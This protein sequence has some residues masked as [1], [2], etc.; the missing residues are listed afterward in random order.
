MKKMWF[1][2]RLGGAVLLYILAVRF[3]ME[4][5]QCAGTATVLLEGG[6]LSE[7]ATGEICAR[8]AEQEI[9]IS[10]CFWGERENA[11]LSCQETG[12]SVLASEV[13]VQGRTELAVPGGAAPVMEKGD[14][15]IDSDTAWELFRTEYA[16]GQTLWCGG[17]AYRV[18]GTF[19]SLNRTFIHPAESTAQKAPASESSPEDTVEDSLEGNEPAL[20]HLLV[21]SDRQT[22]VEQ[23]LL[24]YGLTGARTDF[25]F[26]NILIRNLLLLLPVVLAGKLAIFLGGEA[27]TLDGSGKSRFFIRLSSAAVILTALCFL[28]K[29]FEIPSDMIPTKWSD[30]SFWSDWWDSQCKNFLA[31]LGSAQGEAQLE[32]LWRLLISAVCNIAGIFLVL[33]L[34]SS[35][36]E[37]ARTPDA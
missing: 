13:A 11:E 36:P 19:E 15:L 24:R 29:N 33:T 8:E 27:L 6:G 18:C 30:F 3:G 21:E 9:P 28:L 14:C 23:L 32:L 12:G 16:V 17:R 20:D 1:V 35:D 10:L 5:T 2:L 34:P 26:L 7:K 31:I 22:D 4:N 25:S 37:S